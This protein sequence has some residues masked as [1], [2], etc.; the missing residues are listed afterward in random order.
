MYFVLYIYRGLKNIIF[1]N[2]SE[3]CRKYGQQFDGTNEKWIFKRFRFFANFLR[4]ECF[5][6]IIIPRNYLTKVKMN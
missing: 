5:K 6:Y 2:I 1:I 4:G 3:W